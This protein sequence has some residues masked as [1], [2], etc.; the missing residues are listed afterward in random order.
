MPPYLRDSCASS[1]SSTCLLD[2][3][4]WVAR[5]D[6]LLI[7]AGNGHGNGC[8]YH[9]SDCRPRQTEEKSRS[10]GMSLHIFRCLYQISDR[11][12]CQTATQLLL[13]KC[14]PIPSLN[15]SLVQQERCQIP[16]STEEILLNIRTSHFCTPSVAGIS[17][18]VHL[19]A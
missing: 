10:T 14:Y 2:A 19:S 16:S 4:R 12:P 18:R 8:F 17:P 6:G 13:F 3:F 11:R 7:G 15:Q 9:N 1:Y 5:V